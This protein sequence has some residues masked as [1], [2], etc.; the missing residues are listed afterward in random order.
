M[1]FSKAQLHYINSLYYLYVYLRIR[2]TVK[3]VWYGIRSVLE[4]IPAEHREELLRDVKQMDKNI[5]DVE[6]KLKETIEDMYM[7][8][9]HPYHKGYKAALSDLLEWINEE[10]E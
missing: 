2:D 8:D 3:N 5:D 7:K 1:M 4:K 6:V 9:V 10:D